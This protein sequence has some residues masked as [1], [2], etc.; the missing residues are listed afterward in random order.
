MAATTRSILEV[1]EA[2]E[3]GLAHA[4][5]VLKSVSGRMSCEHSPLL[6]EACHSLQ[7]SV[8]WLLL[9][10]EPQS[11]TY[12]PTRA[13]KPILEDGERVV[14]SAATMPDCVGDVDQIVAIATLVRSSVVLE[15]DA[16]LLVELVDE[17]VPRLVMRC[18]GPGR[19]SD[20][21]VLGDFFDV[22]KE[23]LARRWTAATR[24]GRFE[25]SPQRVEM[26]LR[27]VRAIPE[28]TSGTEA[29][30]G[31]LS[32][33]ASLLGQVVK[34]TLAA[35]HGE[36]IEWD[37]LDGP[38]YEAATLL[39]DAMAEAEKHYRKPE[40]SNLCALLE[41]VVGKAS[42]SLHRRSLALDI[43]CDRGLPPIVMQ[44]ERMLKTLRL[45]CEAAARFLAPGGAVTILAD[46]APTTRKASI[47][48]M[49]SGETVAIPGGPL[50]ASLRR[51]VVEFHS[52]AVSFHEEKSG[53]SIELTLPDPVGQSMDRWIP[54]WESFGDRSK[55]MLRML[56]SGSPTPSPEFL[57][58]GV[59][60]A[61]LERWL[62]PIVESPAGLNVAHEVPDTLPPAPGGSA[63]RRDKAMGQILRRKPRKEI[64]KPPYAAEIVWAF[65]ATDRGRAVLGI[66]AF[67]H[68]QVRALSAALLQKPAAHEDALRLVAMRVVP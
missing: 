58:E 65:G 54:G 19:F 59:L 11:R 50:R 14:V 56:R 23:D 40:P 57:L 36:S 39:N 44:R 28:S 10:R 48:C 38:L 49:Y 9:N 30:L 35:S 29:L 5:E 7:A 34:V 31:P 24:G 41:E 63:E 2:I 4:R 21:V 61:E 66:G 51:S 68:E 12:A 18:D 62:L 13:L 47:V 25:W 60:E 20:S 26:A 52:G 64:A 53:H 3:P 46:Y 22:P 6:R 43:L 16:V 42:E 27:G 32:R 33:A 67:D 17:G 37:D 45:V 55:L 8:N 15:W 1:Y